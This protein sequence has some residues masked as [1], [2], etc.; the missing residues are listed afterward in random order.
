MPNARLRVFRPNASWLRNLLWGGLRDRFPVYL[1]HSLVCVSVSQHCPVCPSPLDTP[2]TSSPHVCPCIWEVK[3]VCDITR[4]TRNADGME[5]S[6]PQPTRAPRLTG[7][8]REG[9]GREGERR[10]I[11]GEAAG[12]YGGEEAIFSKKEP[13]KPKMRQKSVLLCRHSDAFKQPSYECN[14][15]SSSSALK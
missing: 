13:T 9:E 3:H 10:R 2:P 5:W 6:Q 15:L 12:R 8:G 1:S 14:A 7:G 11:G 4:T